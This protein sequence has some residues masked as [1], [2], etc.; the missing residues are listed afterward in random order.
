[1]PKKENLSPET[2]ALIKAQISRRGLIAGAG[3]ITIPAAAGL[4]RSARSPSTSGLRSCCGP[5]PVFASF[6]TIGLSPW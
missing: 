4:H 5:A 1:M 3:G 2:R 6:L